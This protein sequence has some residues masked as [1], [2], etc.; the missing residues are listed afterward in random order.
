MPAAALALLL[1]AGHVYPVDV[2]PPRAPEAVL[3]SP[4]RATVVPL[5]EVN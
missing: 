1:E 3:P 2:A 5:R 4:R